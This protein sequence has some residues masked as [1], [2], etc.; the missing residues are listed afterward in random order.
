MFSDS[1]GEFLGKHTQKVYDRFNITRY[2]VKNRKFKCCIAERAVRTVKEKMFKYFTQ[3]NTLKYIDILNKIE[4]GY[5]ASPNKGLAYETPDKVHNLTDLKE[6]KNQERLQLVQ[7]LKNYGSISKRELES[8]LSSSQALEVG[9]HVRLLL[10]KAEGVFQ[11]SYEP[12]FTKEIFTI[13]KVDKNYHS[14][15][16]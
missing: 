16:G 2:S 8:L 15:T 12:I 10:N 9:A 6:I 3:N 13:R 1:G 5:N 7:K 14:P 4:K 11:K